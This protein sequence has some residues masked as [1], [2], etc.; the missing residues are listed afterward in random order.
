MM[1]INVYVPHKMEKIETVL[2]VYLKNMYSYDVK[3]KHYLVSL[4][5]NQE[6]ISLLYYHYLG[7]YYTKLKCFQYMKTY[8][9]G[10]E[11]DRSVWGKARYFK[12]GID[13]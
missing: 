7:T 3:C 4:P 2:C 11:K 13:I 8:I 5:F 6:S 9:G 12:I 10:Q 1:D